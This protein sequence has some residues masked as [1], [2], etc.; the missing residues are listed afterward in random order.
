MLTIFNVII[1]YYIYIHNVWI[2][3]TCS[4]FIKVLSHHWSSVQFSLFP[5]TAEIF[6][7]STSTAPQLAWTQWVA[8]C[9]LT[10]TFQY[11]PSQPLEQ[12]ISVST[13]KV[14]FHVSSVLAYYCLLLLFLAVVLSRY[15]ALVASLPLL[16]P[17]LIQWT[18][19]RF[20]SWGNGFMFW[21]PYCCHIC[22][23]IVQIYFIFMVFFKFLV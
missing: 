10:E 22:C 4:I 18:D 13:K 11:C 9:S 3:F 20:A 7:P 15:L 16:L 8:S 1:Y 19:L 2:F 5:V 17:A 12:F 23:F 14:F 21:H 6:S